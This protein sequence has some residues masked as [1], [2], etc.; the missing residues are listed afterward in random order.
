MPNGVDISENELLESHPSAFQKLLFDHT[1][2]KNIFWAT[3]S[4][5]DRGEGYQ[6]H[7]EITIEK[8]TG[9]NGLIVRPRAVKSREEQTKRSRDKAEVFTPPWVCNS[10]NNLVDNAWFGREDVFNHEVNEGDNHTWIPTE[11]KIF[12]PEGDKEKTWRKYVGGNVM[13]VSCGEGPYL[14][15]RYDTVTGLPIPIHYRIGLLDR[16]LRIVSENTD[17]TSDWLKMAQKAF[18]STYGFEWQGDNLLLAREALFFTFIDYYKDKF[19]KLPQEA[20]MDYIA[21]IISW[22]NADWKSFYKEFYKKEEEE[23][24]P[25]MKADD[26]NSYSKF[27]VFLKGIELWLEQKG[28]KM[29]Y[30]EENNPM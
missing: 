24:F 1:T 6:P 21:Y 22:N 9:E 11:G 28:L 20:S 17:N 16:K 3:D 30:K 29:D 25:C 12:F 27:D 15:S 19:G 26:P 8:V 13:E 5:A 4:Y 10:Q 2:R 23:D 14:V 7:D 18:M